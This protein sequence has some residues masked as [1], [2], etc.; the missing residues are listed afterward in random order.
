MATKLIDQMTSAQLRKEC[1]RRAIAWRNAH[2]K[3]KHLLKGEM[4]KALA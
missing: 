2:G 1:S 3:G 4:L